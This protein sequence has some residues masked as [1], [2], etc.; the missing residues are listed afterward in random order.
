[1]VRDVMRPRVAAAVVL[2]SAAGWLC[3]SLEPDLHSAAAAPPTPAAAKRRVLDHDRTTAAVADL[4]KALGDLGGNA[5]ILF[6]DLETHET[7]GHAGEHDPKNPASNA[8]IPTAAAALA[9]IGPDHRFTTGLF[10]SQKGETV[11]DLVLRGRGD[12]TLGTD[13]LGSLVRELRSKGVKKVGRILVD[14]SYFDA[15]YVPPAFE[16]QPNEWAYFRAPVAAVSLNEN[17]VVFRVRPTKEGDKADVSTDPPGFVDIDGSVTTA[18]KG[19][20][21]SISCDMTPKGD[22]LGAKLGGK[23]NEDSRGATIV[24][25]VDDPRRFAGYALRSVLREQGIEVGDDV[26]LGG[27]GEKAEK[28]T[29]ATHSSRPLGEILM[30]LG[31]DSDNFAAEM[32]LKAT[33]AE[34][35]SSTSSQDGAKAVE[36]FLKDHGALDGGMKVVNGSGLFDANRST[37][38]GLVTLLGDVYASPTMGP[39]FVAQL[40]IAGVDGTLKRRMTQWGE[41]RAIRAKTGTLAGAVALSGYILGPDGRAP[42]AFS[43]L[44]NG[45]SGK[46]NEARAAIDKAVSTVATEVWK[47]P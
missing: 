17:T 27:E 47:D 32:V 4:D 11:S 13:D 26:K 22:H 19:A 12:P 2:V 40:S 18:K 15:Q 36:K 29:L 34:T 37:A 46:A 14:Q 43:V 21:E 45:V 1:M 6:V 8:K 28:N 3:A 9:L 35:G 33:A 10:G 41:R 16:Q 42:V 5:S 38:F 30:L 39:E 23:I 31:K 20:S 7:L 24:R 44:A 25:R